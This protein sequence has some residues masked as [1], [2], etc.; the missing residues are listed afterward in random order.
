MV[1][2]AG[3]KKALKN[4]VRFID[5]DLNRTW[6]KKNTASREVDSHEKK[7]MFEIIEVLKS[8]KEG[9]TKCYFLDCHT[10]SS[11]SEPFISVQEINDNDAWAHLF[12]TQIIR[13][14]QIL[15]WVV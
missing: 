14:F 5:E 8:Y 3:D 4:N 13:G 7:E 15:S 1:G 2:V 11:A 6:T 10:T 9:F 12:P